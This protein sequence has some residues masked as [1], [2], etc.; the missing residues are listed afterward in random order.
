MKAFTEGSR[1][2]ASNISGAYV[3]EGVKIAS[4]SIAPT[5][6]AQVLA[7]VVIIAIL[8][9]AMVGLV[10]VASLI[11]R[12]FGDSVQ[13]TLRA[14]SS[15]LGGTL[16]NGE[17][18]AWL[19][20]L[21]TAALVAATI[22]TWRATMVLARSTQE[23][24]QGPLLWVLLYPD[25]GVPGMPHPTDQQGNPI[26]FGSYPFEDDDAQ[27]AN[28]APLAAQPTYVNL[29][30]MNRALTPQGLAA[31]IEID[32]ILFFGATSGNIPN[33]P[34][35]KRRTFRAPLTEAGTY[36][37][38]RLFNVGNL[39]GYMVQIERVSYVDLMG[40]KRNAAS[41]VGVLNLAPPGNFNL[42]L[43]VFKPRRGEFTDATDR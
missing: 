32:T 40:R 35:V 5:R 11:W 15:S 34:F 24:R 2:Y 14:F 3:S 37:A 30:V 19:T 27:D 21:A 36:L 6:R 20:A 1:S 31:D 17:L 43:R 8:V 41:G 22:A 38:C 13:A 12:S 25:A 29:V 10:Y 33:H 7:W 23:A 42:I 16:H 9:F 39:P 4:N 26:D 18:A 28:L